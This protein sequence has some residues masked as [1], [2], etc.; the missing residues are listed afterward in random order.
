MPGWRD[1]PAA[2]DLAEMVGRQGQ[3]PPHAL[4]AAC[5]ASRYAI[6]AVLEQALRDETVALIESTAGQVNPSRG[7]SGLTPAAFARQVRQLADAAGLPRHRLLLGADH[8][9]P[10]P[11]CRDKAEQ[12]LARAKELAA[13]CVAAGYQKI[14]LDTSA[15]CADD[16]REP[17][18]GLPLALICHRSAALCR[19]AEE[20]A[21]KH[22]LAPPWYVIG[23]DV[24]L[25]GGQDGQTDSAPVSDVA[26]VRETLAACRKAFESGGL[27]EAW[28][29]V[30]ALV[31]NT[32][33]D[34][35]P[36]VV[37]PYD[38][39]RMQPLVAF[40]RREDKRVFEAHSTDFQTPG[41]LSRMVAD[42]C[43]ILKVGPALT[44]AMRETLFELAAVEEELLA[45]R[46]GTTLS[47]LPETMERLM[48]ADPRHWQA[49][50][51]GSAVAQMWLRRQALSD[52]IRY[53][54]ARPEAEAALQ[55]LMANLRRHPPPAELLHKHLSETAGHP[56]GTRRSLD[57]ERI[58]LERIAVVAAVYNRACNPSSP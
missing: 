17:D 4:A 52:R 28:Q 2:I 15:P 23:S 22:A 14:H 13:A 11:W 56:D 24:P 25:P 49:Y 12:A 55:R 10:Y 39:E 26:H 37:H 29:R 7:Y 8:L 54:W 57:P 5:T 9:G 16:P 51:R 47:R 27:E 45:G 20:T 21:H 50:Y 53:Y 40:I 34:F 48:L 1:I 46:R 43:G 30:V 33:A 32:G 44:Y 18:G 41:A 19:V 58:V 31:V 38:T 36:R 6:R 42:H 3:G 35:S